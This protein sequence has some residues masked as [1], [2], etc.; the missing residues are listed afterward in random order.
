MSSLVNTVYGTVGGVAGAERDF[1]G[2]DRIWNTTN[3]VQEDFIKI[4][5]LL[6]PYAQVLQKEGYHESIVSWTASEVNEWFQKRALDIVLVDTGIPHS[7]YLGSMYMQILMWMS[8]GTVP[9]TTVPGEER[10]CCRAASAG[11]RMAIAA[12]IASPDITRSGIKKSPSS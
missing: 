11:P 5:G 2:T 9:M 1:L 7:L 12:F 3:A 10:T 6:N 4:Y 8:P